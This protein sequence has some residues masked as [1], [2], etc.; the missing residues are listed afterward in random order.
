MVCVVAVV[1][2]RVISLCFWVRC[3]L[4]LC[5]F[6]V[7]DGVVWI[8]AIVSRVDRWLTCYLFVV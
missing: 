4:I 8:V 3:T 1:F 2:V 7:L 5:V 6:V